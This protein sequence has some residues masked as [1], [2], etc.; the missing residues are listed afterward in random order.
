MRIVFGFILGG[1]VS[2]AVVLASL[3]FFGFEIFCKG[4]ILCV[5]AKGP[6]HYPTGIHL[7]W[8]DDPTSTVTVTWVTQTDDNPGVIEYRLVG[9]A[10]W[11]RIQAAVAPGTRNLW[12]R[13][14]GYQYRAR[15][16]GLQPDNAYEYRL[17]SDNKTATKFN[18]WKWP[19]WSETFEFHT[20]PESGDFTLA[21][22]CDVGL[23]GRPDGKANG[24]QRV[25]DQVLD[26]N[27]L[28]ILGGGDYAYVER[29]G[30]FRSPSEIIDAW[31][32]QMQPLFARYPLMAQ[33]GNHELNL[34]ERIKHWAP[35]FAHPAG[36]DGG[37]N[38]SFDVGTAHFV[39]LFVNSKKPLDPALI[40]WLDRDLGDARARGQRW[41]IVYHHHPFFAQGF[42]HPSD[43]EAGPMLAK[44]VAPVLEKNRV[45]LD[46]NCHDQSYERT[47]PLTEVAN[48][49]VPASQSLSEYEAG[50]GVIYAKV[51]PSGK[52]RFSTFTGTQQSF[53]AVRAATHHHY[54]LITIRGEDALEFRAHGVSP[55]GSP[56]VE[57]D[58]FVIRSTK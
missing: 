9:S 55:D 17:S 30:R 34:S 58:S 14:E 21:F 36:F 24:T 22:L 35:R 5:A 50:S 45:D 16:T 25:I 53:M 44:R 23:A 27:P 3:Y 15:M 6:P 33:Y 38:Y 29:D 49:P 41:L 46:I 4:N 54:A 26:D 40:E 57:T 10:D 11:Q 51:S 32:M 7:S 39:G 56:R 31:F 28:F 52:G 20:A 48:A 19:E 18:W 42:L 13:G 12:V 1:A 8:D 37:L 2:V 47:F 43:R